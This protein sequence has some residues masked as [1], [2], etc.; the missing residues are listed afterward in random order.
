MK[1]SIVLL[2]LLSGLVLYCKTEPKPPEAS[3]TVERKVPIVPKKEEKVPAEVPVETPVDTP[4]EMPV[5]VPVSAETIFDPDNIS[6]EE[7]LVTKTEITALVSD[8]NNII[9]TRN[10]TAWV[11]NLS[12]SYYAEISSRKF[13]NDRTEELYRR[14]Q[15]VAQNTGRDPNLVEKRVLR[16]AMDYFNYVVVPSRAND[17][18]DDIS[19]ISETHVRAYTVDERRG[20]QRLVLYDL[21]HIN[22]TWK[23]IN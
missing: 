16:T 8:L 9:R 4:V 7:F 18:L 23:I 19:F 6:E 14:D 2:L 12:N 11:L 20:G 22:D 13:L 15:I 21:A 10:F 5:E 1:K 3:L 17:R